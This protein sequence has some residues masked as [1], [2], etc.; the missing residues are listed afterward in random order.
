MDSGYVQFP[1][2]F[3][4]GAATA[5]Y[6]IEGGVYADGK[7]LSVWDEFC[8]RPG[9]IYNNHT[10]EE[11][12]DFYNRYKQDIQLMKQMGLKMFRFSISWPRVFPEGYGKV[13]QKGVDFYNNVVDELL[14]NEI[15]PFI[16]LNHWDYPLELQKQGGWGNRDNCK[17]FA[18]Y[19]AFMVNR[20]G[21]RVT[22]WTT[23]NEPHNTVMAGHIK[24]NFAPG[25]SD[26]ETGLR[27]LHHLNYSHGLAVRAMKDQNSNTEAGIVLAIFPV[28]PANNTEQDEE[29]AARCSDFYNASY[30]SPIYK[31]SYPRRLTEFFGSK[32]PDITPEDM[33]II[34]TPVDIIGLNCYYRKIV[35][36]DENDKFLNCRECKPVGVETTEMNWEIRPE[37]IYEALKLLDNV[38]GAKNIYITESGAAFN[39]SVSEDGC[40]HDRKRVEYHREHLKQTRKAISEGVDIKG[41]L[42]WTFMDNFEWALGYSKRFG[43]VYV[44]FET[45]KRIIKDSGKWFGNLIDHNNSLDAVKNE[46]T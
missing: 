38:Y 13:N 30:L 2:N 1:K 16:T 24:G 14:K 46:Q 15:E 20:L 40:V 36:Y 17:Y 9:T 10:G 42:A 31:G 29:A 19:A 4:L 28:Y 25:I 43:I 32:F 18:D 41:Y 7:G 12:C 27:V 33:D 34:N 23:H 35:E 26:I 5:S 21:D 39:D 45:Q 3:V 44:D 6:Q 37:N 8:G 11:A 22:K